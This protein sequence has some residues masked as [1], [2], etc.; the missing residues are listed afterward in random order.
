MPPGAPCGNLVHRVAPFF[1]SSQKQ[2]A[3]TTAQVAVVG[4]LFTLWCGTC[5]DLLDSTVRPSV[6]LGRGIG[7]QWDFHLGSFR[8]SL[9]ANFVESKSAA[10]PFHAPLHF[11]AGCMGPSI[12]RHYSAISPLATV[13][14]DSGNS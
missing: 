7:V 6:L 14:S 11:A 13:T 3:P 8:E 5:T 4:A 1:Y 12:F 9:F 2:E 10:F